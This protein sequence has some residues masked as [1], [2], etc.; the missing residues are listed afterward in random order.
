MILARRSP[1]FHKLFSQQRTGNAFSVVFFGFSEK[2]VQSVIDVMYGKTVIVPLKEKGR[3]IA[4]FN[5]LGVGW[6][7]KFEKEEDLASTKEDSNKQDNIAK[8]SPPS[9]KSKIEEMESFKT[10]DSSVAMQ[11]SAPSALQSKSTEMSA[12]G[13]RSSNE[14]DFYAIL[15]SFT[16][17]S[18]EELQRIQHTL[19]G[20]NHDPNRK[21]KCTKCGKEFKHF[22][23]ARNHYDEHEF[24]AFKPVREALR[25]A[26][27]ERQRDDKHISDL[28]NQIGKIEVKSIRRALL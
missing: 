9:K 5:K 23:K 2:T 28:E 3:M 24:N 4:L 15:D 14:D 22:S 25:K 17:T 7:E 26:E 11:P 8:N 18:E 10:P 27:L 1:W 12:V 21:Y 20:D 16:E 6:A 19:V 13:K